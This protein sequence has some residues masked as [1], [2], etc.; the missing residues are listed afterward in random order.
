MGF[1]S[2]YVADGQIFVDP[3]TEFA[4]NAHLAG[5]LL[6]LKLVFGNILTVGR[7]GVPRE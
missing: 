7:P 5:L 2:L 6:G 4:L 3:E 1:I